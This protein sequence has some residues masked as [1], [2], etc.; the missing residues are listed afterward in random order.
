VR[1]SPYLLLL[2]PLMLILAGQSCAKAAG[3]SLSSGRGITLL[4][5]AGTYLF[6]TLRGLAW[7][8][9]LKR[10]KLS[11]AYPVL[12][13]S[14]PLVLLLSSLAFGED[15]SVYKL[16]GSLF[17]LLGVLLIARGEAKE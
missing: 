4:F 3:L 6:F 16:L 9:I 5:V 8:V 12:S 2:I 13:I 11:V 1:H 17:V 14:F 10:M 15:I 7:A